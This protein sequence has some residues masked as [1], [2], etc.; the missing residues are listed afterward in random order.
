[1]SNTV[2]IKANSF[3]KFN[4]NFQKEYQL[5]PCSEVSRLRSTA[6]SWFSMTALVARYFAGITVSVKWVWCGSLYL[7]SAISNNRLNA[8]S[9]TML[10]DCKP[11]QMKFAV[12]STSCLCFT[13]SFEN[14]VDLASVPL[15]VCG[16]DPFTAEAR[17]GPGRL[18]LSCCWAWHCWRWDFRLEVLPEYATTAWQ[19]R[20]M[21]FFWSVIPSI[22]RGKTKVLPDS[23]LC[24]KAWFHDKVE[25]VHSRHLCIHT[26]R[27]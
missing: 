22:V 13:L 25:F 8:G 26:G 3:T 23:A 16:I 2:S 11:W 24:L 10:R 5:S 21:V 27:R 14:G 12:V 4:C 18:S 20:Q 6:A 1:M 15:I 9:S 17:L 19:S 7:G